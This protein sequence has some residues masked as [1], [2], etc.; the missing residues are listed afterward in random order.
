MRYS[1]GNVG[2]PNMGYVAENRVLQAALMRRLTH[3]EN[4]RLLWPVRN[5]L[6]CKS[7]YLQTYCGGS[8]LIPNAWR[9][10]C[11]QV[12]RRS[13]YQATLQKLMKAGPLLPCI[14][15]PATL[16]QLKW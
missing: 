11:R 16:Y 1:A 2:L 3:F 10:V 4:S 13:P 5:Q 14:C 12:W 8:K 6:L 7:V 15:P 9:V